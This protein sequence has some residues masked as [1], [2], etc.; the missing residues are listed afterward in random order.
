MTTVAI[1][2]TTDKRVHEFVESRGSSLLPPDARR[3]KDGTKV[4]LS[5]YFSTSQYSDDNIKRHIH[6]LSKDKSGVITLIEDKIF[7]RI[8]DVSDI[9]FSNRIS[10]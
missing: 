5:S 4:E 1:L 7:D 10:K 9:S 6:K 3:L 2:V 8:S